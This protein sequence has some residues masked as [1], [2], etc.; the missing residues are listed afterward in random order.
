VI[1]ASSPKTEL[2]NLGSPQIYN[3]NRLT[4]FRRHVA[5]SKTRCKPAEQRESL[6]IS[7]CTYCG[8]TPKIARLSILRESFDPTL[9][10]YETSD[11]QDPTSIRSRR[12]G[13]QLAGQTGTTADRPW[14]IHMS[15]GREHYLESYIH[16]RQDETE[17]R[18]G[19]PI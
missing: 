10:R 11:I 9:R 12:P 6:R 18:R 13:L 14:N 16:H 15:I 7:P 3:D 1:C 4:G 19:K 17:S 8:Q 2:P 5:E